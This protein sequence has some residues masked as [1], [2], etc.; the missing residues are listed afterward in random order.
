M[1]GIW[2]Q[3]L[4][5]NLLICLDLIE[6]DSLNDDDEAKPLLSVQTSTEVTSETPTQNALVEPP[7]AELQKTE[8]RKSERK[9]EAPV[10]Y[11]DNKPKKEN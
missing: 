8:Q 3:N 1:V 7:K 9:K 2:Y 5:N 4:N 11:P 10:R 6:T